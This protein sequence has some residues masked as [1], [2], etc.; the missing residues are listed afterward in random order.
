M[1]K[2]YTLDE[3]NSARTVVGDAITELGAKDDRV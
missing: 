2:S 3:Y 1:S